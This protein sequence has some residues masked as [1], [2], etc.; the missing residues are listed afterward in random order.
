MRPNGNIST[1]WAKVLSFVWEKVLFIQK[2][3]CLI[4]NL[5]GNVF[6]SLRDIY[7]LNNATVS[8]TPMLKSI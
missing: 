2:S 5:F 8:K 7:R 3:G 1:E 4:N 6:Q